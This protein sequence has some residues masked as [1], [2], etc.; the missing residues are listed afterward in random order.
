MLFREGHWTLYK[1]EAHEL[2][3]LIFHVLH[4]VKAPCLVTVDVHD[5]HEKVWFLDAV[6]QHAHEH[7]GIVWEIDHQLLSVF[8][9][10]EAADIERVVVVKEK[11]GFA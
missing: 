1:I 5:G 8:E 10:A 11:I 6:I 2:H 9:I 7:I 3:E 4:K